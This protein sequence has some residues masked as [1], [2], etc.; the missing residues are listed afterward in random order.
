MVSVGERYKAVVARRTLN[1]HRTLL[2]VG[3]VALNAACS[4]SPNTPAADAASDALLAIDAPRTP[5]AAPVVGSGGS[6]GI[7]CTSTATVAGRR[8]CVAS[9]GGAEFRFI[10]PPAASGPLR[11][12]VYTH[13][14]GARAYASDSAIKALLP[15]ADAHHALTVA[16]LAPNKCAWWRVPSQ[17]DCSPTATPVSDD[18]GV[19]ADALKAV[20][21]LFRAKYNVALTQNYFYG[22]SGG[23]IFLT[24]SFL[25]KFG[26]VYPGAYALNC[27]GET[28]ALAFAWNNADAAL[29]SVTKL[30]FT[31]GDMDF[32]KPDIEL[33]IPFFMNAGFP[34]DQKVIVNAEHCGF[35]AHGR[36]VE[37]FATY[38]GN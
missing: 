17:T 32:L 6:G 31:Y 20:L 13:G 29:R 23:S 11:L 4:S 10:E 28:P 33:A 30:Y 36:A 5:D 27:G 15:W 22:A 12:V 38:T 16:V 24:K 37:V 8:L 34:I 19:N 14:D 26:D 2:F 1:M 25:R 21:D 9:A 18:A 35:D 3:V 7:T